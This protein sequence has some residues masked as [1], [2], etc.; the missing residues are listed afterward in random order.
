VSD[1]PR[2][3]LVDVAIA[4]PVRDDRVLV[5]K[6]PADVHL[7]GTWEFPGGKIHPGEAADESA[8]RELLEETGLVA[9]EMVPLGVFV[10]GYPD[11]VV[12]LH[13]FVARE[14]AGEVAIPEREWTWLERDDLDPETMP[15]ANR[16]ILRALERMWER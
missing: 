14:P 9:A 16:E 2:A 10:H 12:R 7:A 5:A 1:A 8:R 11:R 4:V 15:E 3:A 13:C 6:R